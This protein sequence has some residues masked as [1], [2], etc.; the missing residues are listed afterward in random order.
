MAY[1]QTGSG[2][3]YTLDGFYYDQ[4]NQDKGLIGRSIGHIFEHIEMK[5]NEN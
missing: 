3:T 1:G 2:K 5:S 4:D